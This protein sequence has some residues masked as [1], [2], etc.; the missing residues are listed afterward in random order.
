MTINAAMIRAISIM[1]LAIRSGMKSAATW[2]C[3][4]NDIAKGKTIEEYQAL[5][6]VEKAKAARGE[7]A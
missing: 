4:R 3:A 2:H 7:K 6:T 1:A 5:A